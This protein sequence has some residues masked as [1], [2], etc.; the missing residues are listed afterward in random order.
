[1]ANSIL[2]RC[3]HLD[4]IVYGMVQDIEACRY[5]FNIHKHVPVCQKERNGNCLSTAQIQAISN[6]FTGP[7]NSKGEALYATQPYDPGLLGSNWAS[8]KFESSVGT[9]RDPVAV[10]IIFKVPPDL[11]VVQ[12]SRQF[13]FNF[14]FDTDYPKLSAIND[15]YQESAMSFMLPPNELNLD[16]LLYRGGK[17]LIVQGA[18]DGVFS[19]DDTQNW[20]D[21]LM[22]GYARLCEQYFSESI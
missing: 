12:N 22:Q 15:T 18:A 4:G 14:N 9:A 3:Y 6:I 8:W 20:Y 11:T 17:M 10:G 1:M 2:A 13:A 5:A 19:V 7:V 21:Q 16:P